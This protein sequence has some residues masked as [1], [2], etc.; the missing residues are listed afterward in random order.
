MLHFE[1]RQL[2]ENYGATIRALLH[3][4]FTLE[5]LWLPILTIFFF[6]NGKV[7]NLIMLTGVFRF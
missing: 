2:D 3:Q 4:I 6:F 7:N 1:N 5:K